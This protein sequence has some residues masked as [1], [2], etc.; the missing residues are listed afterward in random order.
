MYIDLLVLLLKNKSAIADPKSF[1]LLNTTP[2]ARKGTPTKELLVG[3]SPEPPN[4]R[5]LFHFSWL[6][7]RSSDKILLLKI[8]HILVARKREIKLVQSWVLA[9][10]WV[11]F[12]VQG[13]AMKPVGG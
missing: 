6:Y 12:I 3:E 1:G 4:S 8:Q 2:S 7:T 13:V 5:H 11:A 9:L 10:R